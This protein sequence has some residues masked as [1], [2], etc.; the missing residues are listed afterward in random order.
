METKDMKRFL[1]VLFLAVG[2]LNVGIAR[3]EAQANA[4]PVFN[5]TTLSQAINSNVQQFNVVS[6]TGIV[7]GVNVGTM[8]QVD[9]ELMLTLS[10]NP[11][12]TTGVA[13][14]R[15]Q[16]G[17]NGTRATNHGSGRAVANALAPSYNTCGG[18]L[19]NATPC[20]FL[21]NAG[22]STHYSSGPWFNTTNPVA[23][24]TVS[25]L[26]L[27]PGQVLAG[28]LSRSTTGGNL[29]DTLPTAALLVAAIPGAT[30]GTT[31]SILMQNIGSGNTWTIAVGTGGTAASGSTL[32]IAGLSNKTFL[33][34]F[35]AVD[36]GNEAYT[37][38]SSGTSVF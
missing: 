16:R 23:L 25:A 38:Y 1:I 37:L 19:A 3:L 22:N 32:T 34:R 18:A 4:K 27:T 17:Y 14:L 20:G 9:D 31:F 13:T 12:G 7:G 8:L 11:P 10:V 35:T 33:I 29:T 2:V 28:I 21:Y 26:V 6:G 36:S 24:G 5:A 15:V 30:V